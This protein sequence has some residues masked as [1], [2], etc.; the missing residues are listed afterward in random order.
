VTGEE[1]SVVLTD[2]ER[3]VLAGLAA[4][5]DDPWLAQQLLGADAPPPAPPPPPPPPPLALPAPLALPP[6]PAAAKTRLG[7]RRWAGVALI[8]LGALIHLATFATFA[9]RVEVG[10]VAMAVMAAGAWLVWHAPP[11]RAGSPPGTDAGS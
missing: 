2:Q 6:T 4:T 8:V 10:L 7:L 1:D 9:L 5:I 3:E 11:R